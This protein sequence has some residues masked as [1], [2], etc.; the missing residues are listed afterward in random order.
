LRTQGM[1]SMKPDEQCLLS[2][3][4]C[5]GAAEFYFEYR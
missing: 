3:Q 2:L 1:W 4:R 5:L